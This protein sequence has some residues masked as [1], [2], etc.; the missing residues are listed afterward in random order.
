MQPAARIVSEAELS[1]AEL[2]KAMRAGSTTAFAQLYERHSRGLLALSYRMLQSQQDAE[3]VVHDV[4]VALPEAL[5][6]YDE[7][8]ALAA[9][10]KKIAARVALARLRATDRNAAALS[11]SLHAHSTDLD[12]TLSLEAAVRALSPGLRAVLVLKEIEGYSHAEVAKL[13]DISIGASEVRLHRALR[14]LRDSLHRGER[15]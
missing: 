6:N 3:D 4:F 10:L 2:V 14:A 13:L 8:G 15:T 11:D 7:R 1:D 9:W 5:R 12:S